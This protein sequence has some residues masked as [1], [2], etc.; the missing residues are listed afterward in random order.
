MASEARAGVRLAASPRA[1]AA[2][3]HRA[4]RASSRRCRRGAAEVR[5]AARARK[6]PRPHEGRG[7]AQ[8]GAQPRGSRRSLHPLR[9][10][11]GR[12]RA[13]RPA[14]GRGGGRGGGVPQDAV[15]PRPP[16]LF[17]RVPRD[18]GRQAARAHRRDPL[19][20]QAPVSGGDGELSR[21]RRVARQGRRLRHPGSRRHVR[22]QAR[23]LLH[24]R[25]RDA[26]LRDHLAPR[27][28]GLSGPF[29][30]AQR[31]FRP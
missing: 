6:A 30:V 4:R 19:A 25:G 15:R 23:R 17:G 22:G 11:G 21:L 26:A 24:Q 27:R 31:G 9:R 29:F 3:R 12:G 8:D 18:P 16:D 7:R 20:V 28:R 5:D 10:H 1:P 14:E 2:G 13:P